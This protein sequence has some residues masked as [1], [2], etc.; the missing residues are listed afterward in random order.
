MSNKYK[1]M[2]VFEQIR[3]GLAD[4]IAYSRGELSLKTTTL[5][6]PPPKAQAEQIAELRKRLR[7]SQSVFAA[8]LNVSPKTVQSWEQGVRQPADAALRMLQVIRERPQV[9]RMIFSSGGGSGR[10]TVRRAFRRNGA[11]VKTAV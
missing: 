4:S 9:V 10:R 3:E 11:T 2:S 8:T 7:M 5:P 1:T 6:L